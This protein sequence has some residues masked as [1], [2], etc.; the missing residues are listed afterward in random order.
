VAAFDFQKGIVSP[1]GVGYDINCGVRLLSSQIDYSEIKERLAEI[2]EILLKTIP[3]GVG[4]GGKIETR[5]K[6]LDQV[7]EKGA[8]WCLE[9]EIGEAEDLKNMEEGGCLE[10]ADSAKVSEQAKRRG[11]D[12]VGTLGS[13]N[14]FLEI[15]KIEKVF[16]RE[17]A[18]KM[19]LVEGKIAIMIHTGSRGLGHQVATDYIKKL[20]KYS[21]E[22]KIK[23]ADRELI[24]AYLKDDLAKDYL[25]A[26]SAA[27]NFAWANRTALAH[28][29]RKSFKGMGI[30]EKTSD[31]K[32]VYDIAH[33][34]AK[35]EEHDGKKLCVHRKGAT[36]AFPN[37]PVLIP[38]TMGTSSYVL[39]GQKEAMRQTFGS[40]CHG[41]GRVMS[42]KKAKSQVSGKELQEKLLKRGIHIKSYSIRG[43]AE[44]APL[45]YKDIDNVIEIVEMAKLAKRVAQLKPLVVIK[46][47]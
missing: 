2:G 44:E 46:G 26:M 38:G 24:Y 19:G 15:Q 32:L 16:D 31:L 20:Q 5:G 39:V 4:K 23:L 14:H 40:V 12:Q 3:S 6:D 9:N 7:L 28:L 43:L 8:K 10:E 25:A 45:A 17:A 36:R 41:A 21:Q 11:M 42:R 35:V 22:K 33:N 29:A 13:G 37:Q 47:D 27:A 34:M 1:G 18:R 30:I